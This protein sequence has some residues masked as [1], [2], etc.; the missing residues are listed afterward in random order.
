M[1][2]RMSTGE[3]ALLEDEPS[4]TTS[5]TVM[6]FRGVGLLLGRRRNDG[7]EEE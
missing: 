1:N 7:W 4:S 2:G 3:G 6:A 5:S